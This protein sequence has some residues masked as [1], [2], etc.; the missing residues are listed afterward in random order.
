[1]GWVIF[2]FFFKKSKRIDIVMINSAP[3][4]SGLCVFHRN[5]L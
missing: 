5:D 3:V 4:L 1:M 2:L